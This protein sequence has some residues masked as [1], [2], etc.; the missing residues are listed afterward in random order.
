VDGDRVKFDI[1]IC[2]IEGRIVTPRMVKLIP[3]FELQTSGTGDH[4]QRNDEESRRSALANPESEPTLVIWSHLGPFRPE[5]PSR[6]PPNNNPGPVLR[7]HTN[8]LA[9]DLRVGTDRRP[10]LRDLQRAGCTSAV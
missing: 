8:Y 3:V 9:G 1:H 6:G 7:R 2:R 10:I 4:E 5:H